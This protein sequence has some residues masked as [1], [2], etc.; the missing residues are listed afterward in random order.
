MKPWF[1]KRVHPVAE[2][3]AVA[4]FTL[5]TSWPTALTRPLNA[6]AIH[7][8]FDT[9][10]TEHDT[11]HSRLQGVF[12]LCQHSGEH[13]PFTKELLFS[14]AAAAFLRF[15]Q[16]VLT[17]GTACPAGLF[18]P[19]LYIGA[20]LGRVVAGAVKI[21]NLGARLFPHE[22][23]PGVY[24]MVGAAAVL[25]GV[26]RIT[27]SLV[28]IMVELTGGLDY[29]V[30]FMLAVL[31]AKSVGDA[32]NEGIYD[33]YIVL[34]GYP[35]M[36]EELDITF[37]ERCCDI[38][39]TGL[40]KLDLSA[41]PTPDDV[42]AML[43]K[44]TFRGF[45]VV[46]GDRFVG[47][48]RRELLQSGIDEYSHGADGAHVNLE[49]RH[50]QRWIDT[51]VMRMVP[52][53]PLMQAHQVFRQLGCKHIFIVGSQDGNANDHLLGFLSKKR[54]LGFIKDGRVGYVNA[55]STMADIEVGNTSPISMGPSLSMSVLGA[56]FSASA[57]ADQ[58]TTDGAESRT[59]SMVCESGRFVKSD[60]L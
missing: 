32:L 55:C 14:L 33:L 4:F 5:V 3:T 11:R 27:I 10:Y 39:E 30:P 58:A 50:L 60:G 37:T 28:V 57:E 8:M 26:S 25:A 21:M 36:H 19:T 40:V 7:A 29:I 41:R 20:C 56:A 23:D 9:C 52:D 2:V 47:Y 12:A 34:K 16:C 22:I 42:R 13:T 46:A 38:M 54:F 1:K 49:Q 17:I 35:F 53:A 15:V 43:Q 44:T 6:E 18:V 51:T 24:S 45:P 59:Q 31:V 48:I